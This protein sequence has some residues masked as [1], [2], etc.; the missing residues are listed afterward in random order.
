MCID[1]RK[2]ENVKKKN[3][4]KMAVLFISGAL[5]LT[6][7]L[8]QN[9]YFANQDHTLDEMITDSFVVIDEDGSTH[10]VSLESITDAD[11]EEVSVLEKYD[12]VDNV[13]GDIVETYDSKEEAEDAL[14]KMQAQSDDLAYGI[15]A[16]NARTVDVGVVYIKTYD[17]T[18]YK[19]VYT[20]VGGY[21]TGAY[22]VDAAYIGTFN[23]K[24]RAKISGVVADFD[25]ADVNV[26]NY[27]DDA[28][29]SYY[30][31]KDGYLYH[32]YY[33]GSSHALAATR[34]GYAL[35]YL[36][37]NQKYYSYDGHYFYNQYPTMISD[38]QDNTYSSAVNANNPYY[39]YY[40]YLSHRSK[41]SLS[42]QDFNQ[43][44]IDAMGQTS[45]ETS[46]F[47]NIGNDFVNYQ[48]EYYVNAMLMFGVAANESNW[49]RSSIAR[50]KNNLFGHGANDSN[51]YYGANGYDTP[52]HS[53][54][55]HAWH[56]VSRTYLDYEDWRH[57]GSHLGDKEGGM[58]VKYAS[59][60]YWG[61]KAAS[62]SYYMNTKSA[63]Y[64]SETIGILDG[65][66]FD[67]PLYSQPSENATVVFELNYLSNLPVLILD[68]VQAEGQT[69]Y[70][71]QSD[72][73]LN[74][75]RTKPDYTQVYDTSRD[76]LYVPSSA[77]TVVVSGTTAP[78]EP[79]EPEEP[80][81]PVDPTREGHRLKVEGNFV[82]AEPDVTNDDL[83]MKFP[84]AD[85]SSGG[86]LVGS[87]KI[88]KADGKTY[89]VIKLGDLNGDGRLNTS[90]TL[91]MTQHIM[92][93]KSITNNNYL[94]AAD[95][96]Q[97]GR[98]NTSD[99][100]ML[101]QH[102]MKIRSISVKR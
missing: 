88:F 35:S 34:V 9:N 60:P 37:N 76:Y 64:Q 62:R 47:N 79:V 24:I 61:E 30:L 32:Y 13:G 93:Y 68:S 102:V 69:W 73:A 98:V 82:Y 2:G 46:K 16:F 78:V 59:D 65:V 71:I 44:A 8:Y 48:N 39:N 21:V 33:Y 10:V 89:T 3:L 23:G 11:S 49:G 17:V 26:V 27:T 14:D 91:V 74:A 63:D 90:D 43:V 70:K 87:G 77:V 101:R 57:Y 72:T 36:N 31:Q 86:T 40:Q 20:S 51:P 6:T 28:D 83:L 94:N 58:N 53:V 97:D 75:S 100:L 45:Y 29:V 41:S 66:L 81:K 1:M 18:N 38:Y 80:I 19:T 67:F 5:V 54:Q 56:F 50:D 42:G 92:K 85:L 4:K 25:P 95:I 7:A 84:T 22:G 99:S 12:V 52:G 96:N 15:Q 55:D